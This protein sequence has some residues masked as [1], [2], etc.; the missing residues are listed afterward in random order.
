MKDQIFKNLIII[1]DDSVAVELRVEAVKSID[2]ILQTEPDLIFAR[3]QNQGLFISQAFS[4]KKDIK[5]KDG[6]PDYGTLY[7]A[8]WLMLAATVKKAYDKVGN[9]SQFREE[10]QEF[11]FSIARNGYKE[12]YFIFDSEYVDLFKKD[13]EG[14][15]GKNIADL[16]VS[17]KHPSLVSITLNQ[18]L[19]ESK[20]LKAG[21][22]DNAALFLKKNKKCP[23]VIAVL[24]SGKEKKIE[25][26]DVDLKAVYQNLTQLQTRQ[27]I[28]DQYMEL[29][30]IAI[31]NAGQREELQSRLSSD[32]E[33]AQSGDKE[34]ADK[35]V[36]PWQE[37]VKQTTKPTSIDIID[38]IISML[39]GPNS[40]KD[41]FNSR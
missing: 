23:R 34:V 12:A 15:K 13:Q 35:Q 29:A 31:N 41:S 8:P 30:F 16:A 36:A 38:D 17:D 14:K 9:K 22:E 33:T 39:D 24:F 40:S 28:I 26:E 32:M 6:Q 11:A 21:Q 37:K 25:L 27:T 19:D 10:L 2:S 7:E 20:K 18:L 3:N 1:A 4:L 5:F